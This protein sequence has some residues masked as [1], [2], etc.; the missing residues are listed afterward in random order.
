[1][2]ARLGCTFQV[3]DFTSNVIIMLSNLF[4]FLFTSLLPK[5]S[6]IMNLVVKNGFALLKIAFVLLL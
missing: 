2:C 4:H 5:S 6:Y 1:M 3:K